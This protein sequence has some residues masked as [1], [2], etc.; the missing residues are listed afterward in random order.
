M[1]M[2]A[3]L[4]LQETL[5]LGDSKRTTALCAVQAQQHAVEEAKA[6]E[7]GWRRNIQITEERLRRNTM[8]YQET[9]QLYN[10]EANSLLKVKAD[11]LDANIR[12]ITAELREH[13]EGLAI[14]IRQR[15]EAEA[16]L[17]FAQA[18]LEQIAAE[19]QK[20]AQRLGREPLIS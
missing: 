5:D 1:T 15:E 9:M 16:R 10:A 4:I 7:T 13:R 17:Q 11:D 18:D 6:R 2:N 19:C 14:F 8:D 20:I 3:R 12:R